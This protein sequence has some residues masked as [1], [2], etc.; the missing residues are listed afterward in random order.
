[1]AFARQCWVEAAESMVRNSRKGAARD[2]AVEDCPGR[3]ARS[4]SRSTGNGRPVSRPIRS[5]NVSCSADLGG[6]KRCQV[7]PGPVWA[8]SST[9]QV[10]RAC[11]RAPHNLELSASP[12]D[13]EI[14]LSASADREQAAAGSRAATLAVPWA[15]AIQQI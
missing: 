13:L 3:G 10:V 9:N 12:R 6:H 2:M 14:E 4:G 11:A 5:N 15:T 8:V 7:A 1:M